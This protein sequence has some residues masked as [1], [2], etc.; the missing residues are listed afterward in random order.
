MGSATL[1]W[2]FDKQ[3]DFAGVWAD[4]KQP[5]IPVN[6]AKEVGAD[7]VEGDWESAEDLGL[8]PKPEK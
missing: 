7:H 1:K 2:T 5:A 4:I 6:I 8:I 3:K